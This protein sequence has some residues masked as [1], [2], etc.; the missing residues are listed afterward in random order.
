MHIYI[1]MH[2]NKTFREVEVKYNET[3]IKMCIFWAKVT[4]FMSIRIKIRS[5]RVSSKKHIQ[6]FGFRSFFLLMLISPGMPHMHIHE[7]F[8]IFCLVY[9]LYLVLS[10][11]LQGIFE[12]YLNKNLMIMNLLKFFNIILKNTSEFQGK[13]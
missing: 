12:R 8:W 4:Q 7:I 13:V 1:C 9:D 6:K 3:F 2:V 10:K 11:E 5:K